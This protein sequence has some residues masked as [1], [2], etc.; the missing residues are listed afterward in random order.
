MPLQASLRILFH[1][2]VIESIDI[3]FVF[4]KFIHLVIGD[5][6]FDGDDFFKYIFL[7]QYGDGHSHRDQRTALAV[8]VEDD[9][10][11]PELLIHG[12]AGILLMEGILLQESQADD[13]G[14]L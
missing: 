9:L 7:P 11:H 2:T 5:I 3:F 13:P 4:I 8:E 10:H 14:D 6:I 1:N 12:Y